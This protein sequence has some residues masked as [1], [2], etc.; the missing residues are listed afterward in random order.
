[1]DFKQIIKIIYQKK[2]LIFWTTL[3]GAILVFDLVV[4]QKP[5]HKATSKIL[6]VQKQVA[7]QDIYTISKS[8]QYIGQIL[9]EAVYSD[10]FLDKIFESPYGIKNT[11]FPSQLKERRKE[12]A[13]SVKVEI[14]R[15][16]GVIEIDVFYPQK[17]KAEKISQA[18]T[19]VLKE[20]H[21]FYHGAG[22]NVSIKILDGS[23]VSQR[24]AKPNLSLSLI[25]GAI[26]GLLIGLAW[27]F[28]NFQ[29]V[30]KSD[31]IS[32]LGE[33]APFA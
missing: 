19:A 7:G 25:S 32:S 17:D 18:I 10:S 1:M 23:L 15:D 33:N 8:A 9:K 14:L 20:S 5:Q 26:I 2:W 22:E 13:R 24:P 11:D 30:K 31:E 12:W 3:L 28:K 21:E 4:F 27:S 6:V 29:L 16:L